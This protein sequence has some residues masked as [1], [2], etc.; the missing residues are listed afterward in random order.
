[1]RDLMNK[2]AD[3]ILEKDDTFNR[4]VNQITKEFD[5]LEGAGGGLI[6][7]YNI[8][9]EA[10]SNIQEKISR[11]IKNVRIQFIYT[12]ATYLMKYGPLPWEV[13]E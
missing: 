13:N 12:V 11:K 3:E 5:E 1:M 9:I 10:F 8:N 2:V 7:K 6:D 4:V